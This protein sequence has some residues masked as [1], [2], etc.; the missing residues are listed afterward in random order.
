MSGVFRMYLGAGAA[1]VSTFFLIHVL[2]VNV[3]IVNLFTDA[4]RAN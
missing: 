3:R 4:V 2:T 1:N